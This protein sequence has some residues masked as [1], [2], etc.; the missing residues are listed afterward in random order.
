MKTSS[1]NHPGHRPAAHGEASTGSLA[2]D[3]GD[4]MQAHNH[5][6]PA[7]G[8][9][10][11]SKRNATDIFVSDDDKNEWHGMPGQTASYAMSL[12]IQCHTTQHTMLHSLAYNAMPPGIQCHA[13]R[14]KMS[15]ASSTDDGTCTTRPRHV[16]RQP[17][18]SRGNA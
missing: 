14:H 9:K 1:P 15:M 5:S 16:K 7:A 17:M 6:A 4:K 8:A 11:K 10:D 18:R 13:G 3:T 12:S 2:N